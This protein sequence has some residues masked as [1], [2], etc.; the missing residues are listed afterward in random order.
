MILVGGPPCGGKSTYVQQHAR[1]TDVI[2]DFDDIVERITGGDRYSRD[3]NV[4][5]QARTDWTLRIPLSD[6]VIWTAPRRAQRGRFR[7][8]HGATVI[9]V[10]ANVNQCLR[11][12]IEHRP[13]AWQNMIHRWFTE[14]EPSRS[15]R[16][17]IIDT[18]GL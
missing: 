8:Q 5:A 6:W 12:A 3:P 18:T 7:T 15:G 2:L 14:W 11:R 4:L 16:E 13:P 17:Q 10:T 9:V 1:P